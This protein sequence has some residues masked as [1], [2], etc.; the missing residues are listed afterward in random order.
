M[1]VAYPRVKEILGNDP[2]G[3]TEGV[4][5]LVNFGYLRQTDTSLTVFVPI[6]AFRSFFM[7]EAKKEV[8]SRLREKFPSC[9]RINFKEWNNEPS[10]EAFSEYDFS[11]PARVVCAH[12]RIFWEQGVIRVKT[13][14]DYFFFLDGEDVK[15]EFREAINEYTDGNLK[16]VVFD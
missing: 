13:D 8:A 6:A 1:V 16:D 14:P 5:D 4:S 3:D 9:S 2:S 7:E 11:Q 10:A 12:S 15:E